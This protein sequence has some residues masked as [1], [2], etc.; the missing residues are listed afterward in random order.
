M[1]KEN[2][3]KKRKYAK[4]SDLNLKNMPSSN[5]KMNYFKKKR[6]QN[7]LRNTIN[8]TH[9]ILK[10][11]SILFILWLCSRLMVTE[12]WY[13][14]PN[15]FDQYPSKNL[16]IIG[17]KITPNAKIISAL[18][19]IPY[20]RKPLYLINTVPYEDEVEKLSPVKKAFVRRYWLPARLEVTIEEEV[21][22]L[23]FAPAPNAPE[24]D[25]ITAEGKIITKEYLPIKTNIQK[26]YK[27]LTYDDYKKWSKKEI[28]SVRILAERIEDYSQEKLL[29]LDLRNK[30]DVFAQLETIKIRIGELNSTLKE[31]IERLPS[32]MPQ[33]E[34][35]KDETEY[36]DIRWD[37][38]TYLKKKAKKQVVPSAKKDDPQKQT[39]K[40]N[41][42]KNNPNTVT[43]PL[44]KKNNNKTVTPVVKPASIEKKT[45]ENIQPPELADIDIQTIEP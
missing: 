25:A 26:T 4:S 44:A 31:R 41:K 30:N 12:L 40:E 34:Y 9:T 22:I 2:K 10:I 24:V 8:R 39:K 42:K 5:R 45:T 11:F 32:I 14:P 18:K 6:A 38:T 3:P 37:N 36:V 33:M 28:V 19:Q 23:T 16:R 13:L 17:N 15:L 43:K 29:Y 1:T 20:D 7:R 27:V 21:P 35:L